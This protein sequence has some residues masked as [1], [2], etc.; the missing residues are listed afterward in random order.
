MIDFTLTTAR[1]TSTNHLTVSLDEVQAQQIQLIRNFSH[2]LRTPLTLVYGYMQ[3]IHRRNENLTDLQKNALEIAMFEMRHTIKL[4]Q[5]S[6]DLA[7]LDCHAICLR[8]EPVS[9]HGLISEAI[10]IFQQVKER[11]IVVE[12][13][14]SD[15]SVLANADRLQQVL[16]KL[17]DNAVKYSDT[18]ITIRL[19]KSDDFVAISICDHGCGIDFQEQSNIFNPFYR[20]DRSRNR[21]TGGA[22]LGLAIAK[23]LVE[24][25]GGTLN[26]YSQLGEGSIFKIILNSSGRCD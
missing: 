24:G 20:V 2:E 15:I 10:A 13:H 11:E 19:E 21:D 1:E 5:E 12:S 22:G 26:V 7:R 17:I 4:L 3:S 6:L 8:R 18:A 14:Q 16:L 9:L 25:M 23:V